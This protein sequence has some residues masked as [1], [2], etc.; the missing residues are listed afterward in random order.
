[1]EATGGCWGCHHYYFRYILTKSFWQLSEKRTIVGQGGD[2]ANHLGNYCSPLGEKWWGLK[3]GGSRGGGEKSDSE[4]VFWKSSKQD[5][6]ADCMWDVR[7][8]KV[9]VDSS[10]KTALPSAETGQLWV[11]QVGGNFKGSIW[12]TGS[13]RHFLDTHMKWSSKHL[14]MRTCTSRGKVLVGNMSH[15]LVD[16]LCGHETEWDHQERGQR[17]EEDQELSLSES[18]H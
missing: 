18:Q 9:K 4:N 8:R 16:G 12:E 6:L 15:W 7:K 5:F 13:L 14:D 3:A 2:Q 1:M 17:K 11:E 10:W